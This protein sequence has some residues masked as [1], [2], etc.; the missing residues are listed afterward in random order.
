[1]YEKIR[2][3]KISGRP[4]FY[5]NYVVTV[6]GKAQ[7]LNAPQ[8]YWPIGGKADRRAFLN[9]RKHAD[10]VVN[11][12]TTALWKRMVDGLGK[13]QYMVLAGH[14][15]DRLIK[16]FANPPGPIPYLAVTKST[17]VSKGLAKVSKIVRLG[18]RKVDLRALA[19]FLY[20]EGFR[21]VLVEGGS[22]TVAEFLQE[23]LLDEIFLTITPK[24]FGGSRANTITMIEGH[25]FPPG[26]IK[27]LKLVS[28][29]TVDD[30]VFLRYRIKRT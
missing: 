12:K 3:P 27:K 2:F 22:H 6:D 29:E 8:A 17:K 28:A 16:M 9:L 18:E 1:M 11:G 21:N 14:P 10:I 26:K 30:E 4:Y 24:I 20:K 13:T 23:D 19:R 7:V 15:T 25:L 5:T